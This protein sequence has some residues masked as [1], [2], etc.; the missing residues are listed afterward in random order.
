MMAACCLA[1]LLLAKL[2]VP[3]LGMLVAAVAA[4]LVAALRCAAAQRMGIVEQL[5]S[6][7]GSIREERLI[8]RV[9]DPGY[10]AATVRACAVYLLCWCERIMLAPLLRPYEST[11]RATNTV[12]RPFQA[13]RNGLERPSFVI[14]LV[15]ESILAAVKPTAPAAPGC[16]LFRPR[17]AGPPE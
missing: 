5:W 6:L 10:Q 17:A 8:V 9:G 15:A 3:V 16:G 12:G 4:S 13:V 1:H 2:A 11:R 7:Y 14:R